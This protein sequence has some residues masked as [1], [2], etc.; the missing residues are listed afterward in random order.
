MSSAGR[1]A[2]TCLL[3]SM[4]GAGAHAQKQGGVLRV[5][6]R[7][8]PPSASIHEEATISTVMPF[9]SVFNNLVVFDP[10]SRQNRLDR[11]IPE[12]ATRWAWSEDGRT[13]TFTLR[14]DV[15]W[16]DGQK[17]TSSD[18][19][20]TWDMLTGRSESKLRKNPRKSWYFD[21]REITTDGPNEVAFH[22]VDPQPSL[23]ALLAA[24]FS[25]VYPCHVNAAQMRTHPIGTG[26]FK[27]VELKQNESMRVERN[28]DYWKPGRPYLDGVEFTIIPNRSTAILAFVSG[29]FDMTFTGELPPE[30]VKDVQA[31]APKAICVM[32]P[33]NTQGN[34]LI[35][36]DRPPFNDARIRKAVGLAIDR[37][38]FS[39]I[40]SRGIDKLG[41]AMMPPPEGQWGM[42][43]EVL[44]T[45]PGY[46]N[47]VEQA[48]E[49]GRAI[50]RSLGYGPDKPLAIKVST[51][52]IPDYRDA[53]VIL[54]DHL[55]NV[56]IQGE[57]EPIDT[58]V[59]YAR[60]ARKD[61]SVG[62]NVQ[63]VGVDDPDVVLFETYACGSE[64]NY[65]GYCNAELEKLFH[66]QSMTADVEQ[67]RQIVWQI[68]E[69]LQEDG[70]RPVI[71]HGQAGT[72]WQPSVKGVRLAVN[73]IYNHWR[74]E[75]VW[76]DR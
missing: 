41:G 70:A 33:T 51:R 10:D 55:K 49:Q 14:D 46:G 23:L 68:D 73:T 53:A 66:K 57:L 7:D 44:E 31:Q 58:A 5:T 48:R 34:L 40:I 9:A 18:V 15:K 22:L 61:Y 42:T 76:L 3:L 67:R 60:M 65:T 20:C 4:F 63:G 62:M 19:K 47:D 17:F 29:R 32:Q 56:Y 59:W 71:Y 26:P 8:N 30:L 72:C 45:V 37:R 21:V 54:I 13:L 39:E 36:F 28:P 6:H 16:H 35:N 50:M 12:L 27:F 75:D 74:F 69:A 52:N 24:G 64:R 11:I 2:V 38:A 43:P 25:P 1:L